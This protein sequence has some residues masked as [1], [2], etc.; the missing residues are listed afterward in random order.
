MSESPKQGKAPTPDAQIVTK[1]ATA[2]P[3]VAQRADASP[4]NKNRKYT[5]MGKSTGIGGRAAEAVK[6]FMSGFKVNAGKNKTVAK[7]PNR[8]DVGKAKKK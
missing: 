2:K 4:P 3:A 6:G 7:A 5:P 1:S 8:A